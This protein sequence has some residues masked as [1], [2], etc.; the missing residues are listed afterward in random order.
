MR[1]RPNSNQFLRNLA[2]KLDWQRLV[3]SVI[4]GESENQETERFID[5]EELSRAR[6]GTRDVLSENKKWML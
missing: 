6:C 1:A 5:F 4:E 2:A 3:Q